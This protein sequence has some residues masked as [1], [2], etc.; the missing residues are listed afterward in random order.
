LFYIGPPINQNLRQH[1]TH[2]YHR[3]NSAKQ[4]SPHAF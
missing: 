4:S 3:D 1:T 2:A